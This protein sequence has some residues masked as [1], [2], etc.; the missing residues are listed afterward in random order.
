MNNITKEEIRAHFS[1]I[2]QT[3]NVKTLEAALETYESYLEPVMLLE[4]LSKLSRV[5]QRKR[6]RIIK[7]KIMY[8]VQ[9]TILEP[10]MA[11]L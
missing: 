2:I 3:K 8:L 7:L 6:R 10:I 9:K 5:N 4:L 11:S 1:L